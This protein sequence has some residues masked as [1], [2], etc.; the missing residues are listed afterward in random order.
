ME[1]HDAVS[2]VRLHENIALLVHSN[3]VCFSR[4]SLSLFL[5]LS[6]FLLPLILHLS[7]GSMHIFIFICWRGMLFS[8][9]LFSPYLFTF[10]FFFSFVILYFQKVFMH[11]FVMSILNIYLRKLNNLWLPAGDCN[12]IP[13]EHDRAAE[14]HAQS[15]PR[16]KFAQCF[17]VKCIKYICRKQKHH[18]QYCLSAYMLHIWQYNFFNYLL[19][20]LL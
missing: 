7:D 6:S 14:P 15:L 4:S 1:Q 3:V 20:S 5:F 16:H 2:H 12:R 13:A 9:S 8:F 11:F 18:P 19:N 17:S 10:L